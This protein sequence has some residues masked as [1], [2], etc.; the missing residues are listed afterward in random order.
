MFPISTEETEHGEATEEKSL[1]S[2]SSTLVGEPE[3]VEDFKDFKDS[4]KDDDDVVLYPYT[5]G[6]QR[7]SVSEPIPRLSNPPLISRPRMTRRTPY[8]RG[9]YGRPL[10][11]IPSVPFPAIPTQNATRPLPIRRPSGP[12]PQGAKSQS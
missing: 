5:P 2:R 8:V 7:R 6:G 1:P 9:S 3:L 11:S 12:R 10:P 4:P